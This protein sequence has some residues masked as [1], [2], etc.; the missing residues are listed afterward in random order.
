MNK[1]KYRWSDLHLKQLRS[2]LE[3]FKQI[4]KYQE[5][6]KQQPDQLQ[7][8]IPLQIAVQ[9]SQAHSQAMESYKEK[10]EG[11]DFDY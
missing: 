7:S 3:A 9:R 5:V 6:S 2:Q 10:F 1:N 4:V 8:M 11:Y